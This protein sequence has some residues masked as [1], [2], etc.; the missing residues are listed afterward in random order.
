MPATPP[1]CANS[2]QPDLLPYMLYP[3]KPKMSEE[4]FWVIPGFKGRCPTR[5]NIAHKR[6]LNP[7][8]LP[9]TALIHPYHIRIMRDFGTEEAGRIWLIPRPRHLSVQ[10][11]TKWITRRGGGD[12]N[13]R[14]VHLLF[15]RSWCSFSAGHSIFNLATAL[16]TTS[17]SSLNKTDCG[18]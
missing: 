2:L 8:N 12:F 10:I 17:N 7:G 15:G 6:I 4:A 5:R 1:S 3:P 13:Y 16:V 9:I 11:G 14:K 18:G